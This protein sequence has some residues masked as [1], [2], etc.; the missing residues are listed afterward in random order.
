[1]SKQPIK[2][3]GAGLNLEGRFESLSRERVDDGWDIPEDEQPAPDTEVRPDAARSIISHN[4]SPDIPFTASINPYRGCEHG[5]IYC[6]AR[7]SHAYL[8]LSPGLDFETRLF[9]KADAAQ[10]LEQELAKPGYKPSVISLGANTDPYQPIERRLGVTRSIL[11]VLLRCRHPAGIVTKGA[12]LIERDLELLAEMSRHKL[13]SVAISITTLDDDLK[14][15][16]EPRTASPAGRLRVMRK[17][18]DAGVPVM[19]MAAPMI[20]AINDHE[21]EAILQAAREAGATA[22]AYTL[23]RLPYE[24][25][26]LFRDWLQVH[27]PLRAEHVMSLIRQ[28]RGGQDYKSEFGRRMSGEGEFARLIATRFRLAC[29]RLGYDADPGARLRLDLSGFVPP[30]PGGQLSLL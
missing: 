28:M 9:Y 5:C 25:K 4:D 26:T 21:L 1:M 2:G 20:P 19:V 14:R 6:Y 13:V 23:I 24:V 30:S 22:A 3:R 7:P 27:Y 17:L 8:N 16:L 15:R 29:K 10:L 12:A 18:A 11:Q